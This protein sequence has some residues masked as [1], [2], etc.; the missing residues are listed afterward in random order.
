MNNFM[1]LMT[2]VLMLILLIVSFLML[3]ILICGVFKSREF[4]EKIFVRKLTNSLSFFNYLRE[5]T[6]YIKPKS[7]LYN[8]KNT[9]NSPCDLNRKII[10]DDS[11]LNIHSN[12]F[13]T[14]GGADC[15]EN[16]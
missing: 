6:D 12:V 4:E 3:V 1:V 13:L 7:F 5:G 10:I 8:H 16:T 11:Y 14:S 2:D 15:E 9:G